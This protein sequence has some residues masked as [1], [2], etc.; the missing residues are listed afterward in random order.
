[1]IFRLIEWI[2]PF[3]IISA[4]FVDAIHYIAM[5]FFHWDFIGFLFKAIKEII[6]IIMEVIK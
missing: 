1:M 6:K 3:I 4:I 5:L 2:F